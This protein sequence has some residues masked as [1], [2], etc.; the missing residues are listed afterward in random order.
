MNEEISE[1][2]KRSKAINTHSHHRDD[3]FFTDFSLSKLIENT[4]ISWC[5]VEFDE[6]EE[7]RQNFL[8]KVRFKS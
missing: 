1:I 3:N 2:L 5:K 4:Y 7:S 6:S 8:D